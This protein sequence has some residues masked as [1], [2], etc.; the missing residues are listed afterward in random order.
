MH[1]ERGRRMPVKIDKSQAK[2]V[3]NMTTKK[4]KTEYS[5]TAD[6]WYSIYTYKP[7]HTDMIYVP[8]KIDKSQAKAVRNM[9]TKKGKT[10]YSKTADKWYSIYTYKPNHTDMIYVP[11]LTV[12]VEVL[13]EDGN[14]KLDENKNPIMEEVLDMDQYSV[15]QL[16]RNTENGRRF[17]GEHRCTKGMHFEEDGVSGKC[18]LCDIRYNVEFQYAMEKIKEECDK[19]GIDFNDKS[20]SKE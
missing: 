8:N 7:N 4:G 1:K 2:A 20:K 19:L 12:M 3:R 9:T 16:Y 18:P 6:K 17:A 10:E 11:K 13:D 5:K 15:H 14:P